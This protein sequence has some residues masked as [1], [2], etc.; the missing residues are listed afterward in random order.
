MLLLLTPALPA[1]VYR[2]TDADG[3]VHYGNRPPPDTAARPID[4]PAATSSTPSAS[5]DESVRRERQRRLLE[6]FRY[7]REQKKAGAARAEQARQR[8][9]EQCRRL[10]QHW[11]GLSYA[12]P[13]YFRR[14]DG[15][16]DYLSD[17]QRAARK[18]EIRPDYIAACGEAP[19]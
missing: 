13:I 7:E 2:W 5:V 16:R 1:E 14:D 9:A 10:Q 19:Q 3:R 17:E 4:V 11:R 8:R 12:G 18:A 15:S 6:S